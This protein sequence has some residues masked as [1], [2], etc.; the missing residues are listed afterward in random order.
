MPYFRE[1]EELLEAQEIKSE[2][3]ALAA[4]ASMIT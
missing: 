1:S 3:V 2:F 4:V